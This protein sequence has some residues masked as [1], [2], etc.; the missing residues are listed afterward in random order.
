V[1]RRWKLPFAAYVLALDAKAK[2]L[3]VGGFDARSL[4]DRPRAK[5]HGDI[6]GY[7]LREFYEAK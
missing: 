5:G 4:V 7:D 3:Y 2:R 1:K 6:H